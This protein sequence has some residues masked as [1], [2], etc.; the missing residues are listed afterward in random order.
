MA[1]WSEE[2]QMKVGRAWKGQKEEIEVGKQTR[3]CGYK[4]QSDYLSTPTCILSMH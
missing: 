3:K 2:I 1:V 4:H